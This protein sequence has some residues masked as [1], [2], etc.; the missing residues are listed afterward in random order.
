MRKKF[1]QNGFFR[2]DKAKESERSKKRFA[3]FIDA[4]AALAV[5]PRG[6]RVKSVRFRMLR[7]EI[8]HLF[9]THIIAQRFAPVKRIR[10]RTKGS[11]PIGFCRPS[12]LF[13]LEEQTVF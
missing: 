3:V 2:N 6:A 8:V 1:R 10:F 7:Y 11:K 4:W 5:F 13:L 9:Y 12:I